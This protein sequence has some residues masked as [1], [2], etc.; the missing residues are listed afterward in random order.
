M[1]AAVSTLPASVV[2]LPAGTQLPKASVSTPSSLLNENDFLTLLTTQLEKQDPLNPQSPSDFAAELAQFSTANGVQN[3]NTALNAASG[4][5]A[6]SL[7]GR[8]VAVPGNALV[9]GQNG[10]ATGALQLATAARDVTVQI[11]D[12]QGKVVAKLALGAMSAGNQNFTWNGQGSNGKPLPSGAYSFTVAATGAQGASVT[13]KAYT[14]APVTAVSF[15][16]QSGATVELG[17]GI[18]PTALSAIQQV[19]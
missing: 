4:L 12:S 13:A 15:N 17:N 19:F 8:N 16:G 5:Q 18:A 9:L 1:T 11:S 3:L 6:A 7:V 2:T 10:S 14:I